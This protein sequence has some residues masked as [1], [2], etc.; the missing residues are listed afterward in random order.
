MI[1][2]QRSW[3]VSKE[4]LL[5]I[6]EIGHI[7]RIM[8]SLCLDITYQQL[9]NEKSLKRWGEEND[10]RS[11]AWSFRILTEKATKYT[12]SF[13]QIH[14]STRNVHGNTITCWGLTSF[15]WEELHNQ[16]AHST[17]STAYWHILL[18]YGHFGERRCDKW[19]TLQ[20]WVDEEPGSQTTVTSHAS[21][22]S[23][24]VCGV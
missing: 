15:L 9:M 14:N 4:L 13:V 20:T 22:F 6:K 5:L 12:L 3:N 7:M 11:Y 24:G 16:A 21:G 1:H 17:P 10:K 8:S 18:F 19:T 23:H 2:W